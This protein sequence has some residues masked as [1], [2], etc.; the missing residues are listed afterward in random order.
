[1]DCTSIGSIIESCS[2]L[3]MMAKSSKQQ[4]RG[5]DYL[6]VESSEDDESESNDDEKD[7][8]LGYS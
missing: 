4:V 6:E 1:L 5:K 7:Q 8:V 2:N 3:N